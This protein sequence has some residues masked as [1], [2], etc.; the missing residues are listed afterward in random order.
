M[1]IAPDAIGGNERDATNFSPRFDKS[2][3]EETGLCTGKGK[4]WVWHV[5]WAMFHDHMYDVRKDDGQ[6]DDRRFCIYN[7]ERMI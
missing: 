3:I 2:R 7:P 5:S 4:G 1:N 6:M